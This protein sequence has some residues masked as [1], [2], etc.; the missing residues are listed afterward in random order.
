M[1]APIEQPDQGSMEDRVAD[2]LGVNDEQEQPRDDLED[3]AAAASDEQPDTEASDAEEQSEEEDQESSE[4][5]DVEYDGKQYQVPPE[6]KD[7]LMRNQDYTRKTTELADDR[8]QLALAQQGIESQ[9]AQYQ[10]HQEISGEVNQLNQADQLL[11]QYDQLDWANMTTDELVRTKHDREMV[12]RERGR[13]LATLQSRQQEFSVRQQQAVES[14]LAEGQQH[15]AKSIDGWSPERAAE[16]GKFAV[17]LGF[18]P[19]EVSTVLDPR[20]VR[21]LDMAMRWQNLQGDGQKVAQ[22]LE[23]IPPVVEAKPRRPMPDKVKQD[24]KF[25]KEMKHAKKT[26]EQAAANLIEKRLAGRF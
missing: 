17:S 9:Q 8:R 15:L 13:I 18:A 16:I 2:A 21:V 4:F 10:F 14:L 26:S 20:H 6:L 7:A 19:E 5:A 12:E 23:G 3:Q 25:R 22:K 11:G 24:L 1:E